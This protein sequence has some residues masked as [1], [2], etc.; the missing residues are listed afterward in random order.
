MG[1]CNA[2]LYYDSPTVNV[3]IEIPI[4]VYISAQVSEPVYTSIYVQEPVPVYTFPPV[5]YQS[6]VHFYVNR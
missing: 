2:K 1:T 4:P 5:T 6:S 3:P